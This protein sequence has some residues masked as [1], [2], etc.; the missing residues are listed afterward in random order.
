MKAAPVSE[1][2]LVALENGEFWLLEREGDEAIGRV[3]TRVQLKAASPEL[4][5]SLCRRETPYITIE[6]IN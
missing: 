4:F 1:R 3:V 5:A 2:W 6:R